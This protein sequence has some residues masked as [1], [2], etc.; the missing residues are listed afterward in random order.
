MVA[1]G[2][3]STDA[4]LVVQYFEED[5]DRMRGSGNYCAKDLDGIL[6]CLPNRGKPKQTPN[7]NGTVGTI[8]VEP[9]INMIKFIIMINLSRAG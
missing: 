7:S 5:S 8:K 6:G 9:Y 2:G 4:H 3:D 1:A